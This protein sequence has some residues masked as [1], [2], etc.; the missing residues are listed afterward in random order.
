MSESGR[1]AVGL[2]LERFLAQKGQL[3]PG[4]L[5]THVVVVYRAYEVR[6]DG[7]GVTWRGRAY[8]LGE[9]DPTMERGMLDDALQDARR[10][11][12]KASG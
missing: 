6:P 1:G 8:P 9:M 2:A 11:R 7:R 4:R 5:L 12:E 10:N 3:P